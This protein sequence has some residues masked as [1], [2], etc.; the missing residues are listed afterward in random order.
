MTGNIDS[1][2]Y[3]G[4][5]A[6]ETQYQN[7]AIAFLCNEYMKKYY[8]FIHEKVFLELGFNK[9]SSYKL[10]YDKFQGD[11]W[12]NAENNRPAKGFGIRIQLSQEYNRAESV[13]KLL[14]F[15]LNHLAELKKASN[16]YFNMNDED[17]PDDLT[18]EPSM[19]LKIIES[20][21][22]QN[23]KNILDLKVFRNLGNISVDLYKEYYFQNDKY[24]FVDFFNND[25][26]Y[27]ELNQVYQIINEYYLGTLIFDTDS[28]GYFYSRKSRQLSSKFVINDKKQSFYYSHTASDNDKNRIYFEYDTYNQG[29]KK[30][31]Y[32]TDKLFLVQK[33]E[34]IEDEMIRKEIEKCTKG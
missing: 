6:G 34:E 19:L 26:V 22:N 3:S 15:S 23:I 27:L 33:V 20:S 13:L 9:I 1:V 8:P 14:D 7:Q 10:S 18:I 4:I 24:Y 29:K 12:I 30:F 31:I 21:T 2:Y 28:T 32:L 11:S 16:N 17:R 5:V 25:S